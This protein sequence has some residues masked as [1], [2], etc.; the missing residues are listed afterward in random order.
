MAPPVSILQDF[1]ASVG[2]L[3]GI[4]SLSKSSACTDRI[5]VPSVQSTW[6][7][8]T[9]VGER[10]THM[11]K[12]LHH[13]PF[14]RIPQR[15]LHLAVATPP[16]TVGSTD[17]FLGHDA[18]CSRTHRVG[19]LESTRTAG[20]QAHWTAHSRTSEE[21]SAASWHVMYPDRGGQAS[22][23]EEYE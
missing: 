16:M 18:P 2:S 21:T 13:R 12:A 11:S 5:Q 17:L 4:G 10:D 15:D 23:A 6:S 8:V 3:N 20:R 14:H 1:T 9:T 19:L 7:M 22:M